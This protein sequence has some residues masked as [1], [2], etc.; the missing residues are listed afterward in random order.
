MR[1]KLIEWG[2]TAA[3]VGAFMFYGEP[4][5]AAVRTY[6]DLGVDS[7]QLNAGL[8]FAVLFGSFMVGKMLTRGLKD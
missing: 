7:W 1:K 3:S 5:V 6:F 4:I 8:A 2:V